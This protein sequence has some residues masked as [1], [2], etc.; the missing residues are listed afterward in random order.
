MMLQSDPEQRPTIKQLLS[1]PMIEL[2][3][4]QHI[5][6]QASG[7]T[8]SK[9]EDIKL[10]AIP[11]K[12]TKTIN[13]TKLQNNQGGVE[14]SELKKEVVKILTALMQSNEEIQKD[15]RVVSIDSVEEVVY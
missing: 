8:V 6:V 1:V 2:R 13:M 4:V 7:S 15:L 11:D 14:P 5:N 9:E 12:P 3:M 10:E